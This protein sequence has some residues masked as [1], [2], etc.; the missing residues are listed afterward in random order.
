MCR[1]W[2]TRSRVMARNWMLEAAVTPTVRR[3]LSVLQPNLA[4]ASLSP[5]VVAVLVT[6]DT[7]RSAERRLI[8]YAAWPLL[9]ILWPG[10]AERLSV[11]IAQIQLRHWVSMGLLPSCTPSIASL[12]TVMS[13]FANYTAADTYLRARLGLD[14]WSARKIAA[15]YVGEARAYHVRVLEVAHRCCCDAILAAA[16]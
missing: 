6:E 2:T 12:R 1:R 7:F 4:V 8:E 5:W 14:G 15:A 9:F 11:G 3:L 10:R 16:G 13:E